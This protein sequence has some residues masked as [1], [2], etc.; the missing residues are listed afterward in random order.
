MKQKTIGFASK[1]V[2]LIKS[3]EKTLT[4]RLGEKY[5]FLDVGDQIYACNS[6]TDE[7]LALFKIV[8]KEKTTFAELPLDREGHEIY[9]S[10]EAQ[11]KQFEKY[12]QREVVDGE[13]AVILE[14]KVVELLE[15]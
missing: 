14:F 6:A 13:T 5:N 2:P 9:K 3:G 1:L 4:Y 11:R 12:Y 15:A 8:G 10:K 7:K